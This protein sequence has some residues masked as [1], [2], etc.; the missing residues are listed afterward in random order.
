MKLLFT[1]LNAR[2]KERVEKGKEV[3]EEVKMK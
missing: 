1:Y 2:E 3:G